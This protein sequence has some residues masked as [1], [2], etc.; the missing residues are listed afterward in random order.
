MIELKACICVCGTAGVLPIAQRQSHCVCPLVSC[1]LLKVWTPYC[2]Q[3]RSKRANR[4]L[5]LHVPS[6]L[7]A[8]QGT[9]MDDG[10]TILAYPLEQDRQK[11]I[12]GQKHL[13]APGSQCLWHICINKEIV[14]IESH[15]YKYYSPL[16]GSH[17]RWHM[18]P[19]TRPRASKEKQVYRAQ[20]ETEQT[21]DE[22]VDKKPPTLYGS[23][24]ARTKS[25]C[26]AD[27][28]R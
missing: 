22:K 28:E 6:H 23:R 17:S 25:V 14:L 21:S 12:A 24:E 26:R 15:T 9:V 8:A 4:L 3:E 10:W 11:G 5:L 18:N 27:Q 1:W 7:A 2:A 16:M 20:T 19:G 13:S